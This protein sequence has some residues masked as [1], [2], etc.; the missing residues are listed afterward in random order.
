MF[1]NPFINTP[2]RAEDWVFFLFASAGA[3]PESF[4]GGG[5]G[6]LTLWLHIICLILK[7]ML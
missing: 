3:H 6:A 4:R 5:G 1:Y 7:I 2:A